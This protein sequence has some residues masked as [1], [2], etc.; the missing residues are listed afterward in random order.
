MANGAHALVLLAPEPVAV[1]PTEI[2]QRI[3]ETVAS[4]ATAFAFAMMDHQQ[5]GQLSPTTRTAN[6]ERLASVARLRLDNLGRVDFDVVARERSKII[7]RQYLDDA[8]FFRQHGAGAD[9]QALNTIIDGVLEIA[10]RV[11]ADELA[12]L[13]AMAN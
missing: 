8:G 9:E 1:V 10:G 4:A 5:N 3:G 2:E 13:Q 11:V 6:A 7:L 12:F